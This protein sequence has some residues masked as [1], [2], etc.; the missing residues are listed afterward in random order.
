LKGYFDSYLTAAEFSVVSSK[1]G[2]GSS[3]LNMFTDMRPVRLLGNVLGAHVAE[4]IGEFVFK[5][6]VLNNTLSSHLNLQ[7]NNIFF[8]KLET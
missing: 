6:A 3:S 8:V 5:L 1:S 4:L 2:V 7:K